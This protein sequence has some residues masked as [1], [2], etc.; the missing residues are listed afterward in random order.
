VG[1]GEALGQQGG[2]QRL[3]AMLCCIDINMAHAVAIGVVEIGH[4]AGA[5]NGRVFILPARDVRP[6]VNLW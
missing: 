1:G 6:H 5:E 3:V 4:F 2:A